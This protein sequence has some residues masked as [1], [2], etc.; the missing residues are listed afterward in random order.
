MRT[1]KNNFYLF[2]AWAPGDLIL[3]ALQNTVN[4]AFRKRD[5][6]WRA[7]KLNASKNGELTFQRQ[8]WR[9]ETSGENKALIDPPGCDHS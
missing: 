9:S 7:N 1:T 8:Q 4:R 2:P 3:A 6:V 5:I